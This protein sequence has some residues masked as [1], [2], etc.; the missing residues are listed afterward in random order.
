MIIRVCRCGGEYL[1]ISVMV[2]GIVLFILM[3]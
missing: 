3:L 2:L 1:V